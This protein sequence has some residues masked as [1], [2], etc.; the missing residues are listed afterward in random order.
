MEIVIEV[1]IK[2]KLLEKEHLKTRGLLEAS[3]L[4]REMWARTPT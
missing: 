3:R 2:T 4:E 1:Q